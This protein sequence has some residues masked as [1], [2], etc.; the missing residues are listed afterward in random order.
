MK[1]MSQNDITETRNGTT[2]TKIRKVLFNEI[3]LILAGIAFVSSAIFWV[4]NPQHELQI[5]LIKLEGR[6][7]TTEQV[8]TMLQKFKDN[9]LHELS[10]RM[11]NIESAQIDIIKSL[12][13]LEAVHGLK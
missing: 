6:L 2:D 4:S 10:I 13:R 8:G 3:S 7:E 12:S 9:D 11:G 5:Q 1:L